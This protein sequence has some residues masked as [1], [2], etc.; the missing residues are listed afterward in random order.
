MLYLEVKWVTGWDGKTQKKRVDYFIEFW[1]SKIRVK[2]FR[3]GNKGL[4]FYASDSTLG[5]W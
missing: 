1:T 3:V 2:D 5:S 4:K